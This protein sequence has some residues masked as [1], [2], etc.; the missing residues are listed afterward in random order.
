MTVTEQQLSSLLHRLTPEPPSSITSEDLTADRD[1]I[2][3]R[4]VPRATPPRWVPQFAAAATIV[5][6]TVGGAL[7]WPHGSHRAPA[8]TAAAVTP[9]AGSQ[10]T[11]RVARTGS[12]AAY[13]FVVIA[14]TNTS[15]RACSVGRY[16]ALTVTGQITTLVNGR[17]AGSGLSWTV[18]RHSSGNPHGIPGLT[19]PVSRTVTLSP[20]QTASFAAGGKTGQPAK[21]ATTTGH[22]LTRITQAS[23][24]SITVSPSLELPLGDVAGAMTPLNV[25][26]WARGTL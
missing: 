21:M 20:G 17:P 11:A 13:S 23:G 9:C 2:A 16:P 7:I 3:T 18:P 22:R 19:V 25:T 4:S 26:A 12:T 8:S 14:A 1:V 10:L 24:Q 6:A 15:G 5:A